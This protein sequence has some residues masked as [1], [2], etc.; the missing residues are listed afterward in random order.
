MKRQIRQGVWETNS[1][2]THTCCICSKNEFGKWKRGELLYD[3]HK[4]ELVSK[5]MLKDKKYRPK[6]K[7]RYDSIKES[8]WKEFEDL[9]EEELKRF[10]DKYFDEDDFIDYDTWNRSDD[11]NSYI[12][13]YTTEQG[14]EIVAFGQYGYC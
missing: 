2:S 13:E 14:E 7:A 10:W 5:D 4:E 3:R 6:L 8:F 1:S 11:L 12:Q 9:T